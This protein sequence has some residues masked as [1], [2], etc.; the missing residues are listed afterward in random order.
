MSTNCMSKSGCT[1]FRPDAARHIRTHHTRHHPRRRRRRRRRGTPISLPSDHHRQ[2]LQEFRLVFAH[3]VLVSQLTLL[4]KP[5]SAAF[6]Y[7]HRI[8]RPPYILK[9]ASQSLHCIGYRSLIC[10]M[11]LS[12]TYSAD[13]READWSQPQ[14]S[15]YLNGPLASLAAPTS[16]TSPSSTYFT[17]K[18][19]QKPKLTPSD[20][21]QHAF[22]S[23]ATSRNLPFGNLSTNV[24]QLSHHPHSAL[25]APTPEEKVRGPSSDSVRKPSSPKATWK[26]ASAES[27]RSFKLPKHHNHDTLSLSELNLF[28]TVSTPRPPSCLGENDGVG[29][30]Q[31]AIGTFREQPM[32]TEEWHESTN[33][34]MERRRLRKLELTISGKEYGDF[35]LPL[36]IDCKPLEGTM[37]L[38]LAP[39]GELD[40]FSRASDGGTRLI[41]SENSSEPQSPGSIVDGDSHSTVLSKLSKMKWKKGSD[42]GKSM[43]DLIEHC[44]AFSVVNTNS[45]GECEMSIL[46]PIF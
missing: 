36:E 33:R 20:F 4:S 5:G 40:P 13:E 32:S 44:A 10:C 43:D 16:S 24:N 45:T 41:R 37:G 30:V 21:L 1:I 25:S 3:T 35:L 18:R 8:A 14:A 9:L 22:G 39:I 19:A 29:A 46:M 27:F 31:L 28:C 2:R 42:L 6:I 34:R 23:A 17:K 26:G 11:P 38:G 7:R 12:Y 15:T